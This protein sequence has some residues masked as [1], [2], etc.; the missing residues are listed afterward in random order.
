LW[1]QGA[2]LSAAVRMWSAFC[3][4]RQGGWGGLE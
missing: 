1:A 4:I 3:G 2:A